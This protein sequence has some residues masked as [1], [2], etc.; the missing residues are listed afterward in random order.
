MYQLSALFSA[1]I[2]CDFS[3]QKR[4]EQ[5]FVRE[6]FIKY[7]YNI[8]SIIAEWSCAHFTHKQIAVLS[9]TNR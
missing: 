6:S 5:K 9:V 8:Y 2:C 3:L 1:T 4:K 7:C